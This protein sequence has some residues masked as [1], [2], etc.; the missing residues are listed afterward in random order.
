LF[1]TGYLTTSGQ[2]GDEALQ[3][4]QDLGFTV[5]FEAQP[6]EMLQEAQENDQTG[7]PVTQSARIV[8]S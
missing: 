2:R 6:E 1:A 8:E 3:M 5:E 7:L 4:I